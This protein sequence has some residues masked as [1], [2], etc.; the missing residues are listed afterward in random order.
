MKMTVNRSGGCW[1]RRLR[2]VRAGLVYCAVLLAGRAATLHADL[3]TNVSDIL[4]LSE[5]QANEMHP[6][7]ITGVV[8]AADP[9]WTGQF[10]VQDATGGIFADLRSTEHPV[11]GDI[12]EVSGL[13]LPGAYAPIIGWPKW[14]KLGTGPLPKALPV[15]IEQLMS[16]I[17]DGQ[18]VVVSGIVRNI[19][20]FGKNEYHLF[21]SADAYRL[22]VLSAI[23]AGQ[24]PLKLV[25]ARV[26]VEGTATASY[27][28]ALRHLLSINIFVPDVSGLVIEDLE[29][30]NP[31]QQA[32]LPLNSIAQYRRDILP[33]KRVHVR[34]V[35]TLKR[36]GQDFFIQDETGGMHVES[37]Q[38]QPMHPG[39][40]VDVVGFPEFDN[41]LPVLRDSVYSVTGTN[42]AR[43][44][45]A[46]PAEIRDI[47]AGFHHADL[48]TMKAKLLDHSLRHIPARTKG[49]GTF[50]TTLVLQQDD[51]LFTAEAEGPQSDTS[52]VDIPVGSILSITGVCFTYLDDDY[53]LKSFQLLMPDT[54]RFQLIQKPSWLTAKRLLIGLGSLTA[55]L[56]VAV[57]WIVMVLKRNSMLRESIR[58]KEAAQNA[59]QEANDRLDERV[60]ERTEQLKFQITARKESE[61]Q[62]KAVLGER[63]RLA[64]ELHDT[65]EQS[66]TGIALQLDASAKLFEPK[67]GTAKHHLGLARNLVSQSQVDV[68][69]S[70]WDLRSRALQQFDLSSALGSSG[71]QITSGT[72]IRFEI[73]TKGQTAPL[74]EIV[75]E[76]LLRIAQEAMTNV[77]KHSG[78]TLAEIELDFGPKSVSLE[79]RDNGRGFTQQDRPGPAEGHFG[80]Q[81]MVER[82]N[83][84][85]ARLTIESHHGTT[86]RIQVNLDQEWQP[87]ESN[88]T[89][90]ST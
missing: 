84:L 78:A 2:P 81:G 9:N 58:Q 19:I 55:V 51:Q 61:L 39:D 70:I 15:P 75:E 44:V 1:R 30:V 83:R 62:F 4:S 67:P 56:L 54:G 86:I 20:P 12:V 66:L 50:R 82:A 73:R 35:V 71:K 57:T 48:V 74:P 37:L 13:T 68:R 26:R 32:V 7:Q 69:R 65:L 77:I 79:I 41:F 16:G 36:D 25:G 53:H 46:I 14:R 6:V 27:N 40:E 3:L 22:R 52:L 8:T 63:T 87:G 38:V 17:R 43:R 21:L 64:Q 80:L 42:Q 29:A 49:P 59:L 90:L 18:R 31:F 11:P 5:K 72:G 10:I 28:A 33:G 60:R 24:D 88:G 34:G 85:N 45:E 76:N 89:P 23:P 47:R